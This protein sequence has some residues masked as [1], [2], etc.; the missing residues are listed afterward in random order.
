[1]RFLVQAFGAAVLVI[2]LHASAAAAPSVA[3]VGATLVDVSHGGRSAH[4]IPDAVVVIEGDRIVAAGTRQSTPIP[5]HAQIIRKPGKFILPGLVD[6]FSGLQSQAEANAELYEGVTTVVGTGD[7]RRGH[8]LEHA[9]PSPHLYPIDSAGSTDDWSLLRE[10]PEW[11]DKLADNDHPH[12]LTPAETKAQLAA[13][14]KRGT[15]AIWIGW[16]ITQDNARAI[17]AESHRL[18]MVTYGEFIATPYAVGL[19]DG[20]DVLLHMSRYELGL[21][22]AELIGPLDLAPYGKEANAAYGWV[23]ASDPSSPDVAAYGKAIAGHGVA[24][25]PTFSLFYLALPE[26]R[27]LWKERAASILDPHGL[28]RPSDPATGEAIVPPALRQKMEANALHLWRLNG[29]LMDQRPTYLAG[30]GASALGALPGIGLHVELELLVRRG[31]PPRQALAA[32]TSNYSAQF[33]W[34]ELGLVA[35]GRRADLV[36][37]DADPTKDIRNA[38]RISDVMLSGEW[39]DRDALL[40]AHPTQ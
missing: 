11:H 24:L 10:Q 5:T 6:G 36:L 4:D 3:L 29:Y 19:S 30:S 12:E 25:M 38:A 20:V 14:A 21:A 32:A 35:P 37:V 23:D 8:L 31:L 28:F 40:Q 13:T 39:L 27:N 26:H 1:M 7:D 17:I 2:G 33:H 15:R 22:P 9:S 16:N 34:T 18:G